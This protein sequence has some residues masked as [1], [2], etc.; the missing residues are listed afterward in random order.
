MW[1][2]EKKDSE[3][4]QIESNSCDD[5]CEVLVWNY[6]ER[7]N[8]VVTYEDGHKS[9]NDFNLPFFEASS[10][11]GQNIK[12]VFYYLTGEILKEPEERYF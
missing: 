1:K 8:R 11:T 10:T 6:C 2:R 3:S 12:E 7:T 4:K 5:A 9:V